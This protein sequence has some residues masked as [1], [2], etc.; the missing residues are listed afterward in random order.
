MANTYSK[1]QNPS[2]E[3]L[4]DLYFTQNKTQIEIAVLFSTTQKVVWRWFKDLGI[5]SRVAAKR[6]QSRENNS[7]WKGDNVT[8]E[9]FHYR[10]QAAKGKANHCDE[11]GRSDDGIVYDWANMTGRFDYV[12]DYKQMCRSCH[13]KKDGHRNNLPNRI[14]PKNINKRKLINGK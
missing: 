1:T 2:K 3:I 4:T 12:D 7:S 6:N 10:V 8:Y 13:F 11:C 5:K 9:A 14:A